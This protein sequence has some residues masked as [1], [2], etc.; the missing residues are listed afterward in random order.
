MG[1]A[2]TR[3]PPRRRL[4]FP[5]KERSSLHLHINPLLSSADP[6]RPRP[7]PSLGPSPR[8]FNSLLAPIGWCGPAPGHVTR[9]RHRCAL[10]LDGLACWGEA[11]AMWACRLLHAGLSAAPRGRRAQSA[12]TQLRGVLEE[13]LE[14]IR[15]A[16]TWKSERVITSR[17]G[18]RI[19]VDGVS[20]GN[21]PPASL[22]T[23]LGVRRPLRGQRWNG[24]PEGSGQVGVFAHVA[25]G[26][27]P[28]RLTLLASGRC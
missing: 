20:G 15:G 26:A 28:I 7:H 8:P 27:F 4:P 5:L 14:A 1:W 9:R 21:P 16:G 23:R 13:E 12:L 17:Q 24:G 22:R 3:H 18:P 10:L 11:G 2:L 19:H 6:A 25:T